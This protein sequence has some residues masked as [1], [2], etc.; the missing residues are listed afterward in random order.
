MWIALFR[1][2]GEGIIQFLKPN[3]YIWGVKNNFY[4][5]ELKDFWYN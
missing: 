1:G 2:T 5:P 4:N 3:E